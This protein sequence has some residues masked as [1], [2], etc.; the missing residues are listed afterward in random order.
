MG[1]IES[2]LIVY[3]GLLCINVALSAL[4]W[5]TQRTP[6][7]RSL[8]FVW[9]SQA[10]AF[11][12][13]GGSAN[14]SELVIVYAFSSAFLTNLGVA[15]LLARVV[16]LEVPWRA[17]SLMFAVGCLLGGIA[18][19]ARAPFWMF[20]LPVCIAVAAPLLWTPLETLRKRK[21]ALTTTGWALTVTCLAFAAHNL[22][23]AFLRNRP[24]FAVAGFTIAILLAF[25]LGTTA[26][27]VV[28]EREA[29]ERARVEELDRFKSKFF[30]SITHELKTPLT[31]ILASLDL[32]IDGELGSITGL[33]R[34]TLQAA[35]RSGIKLLKLIADLLDLSKLEESRLRLRIEEQDLVAYLRELLQQ[36][37][38]LAERK[39]VSVKFVSNAESVAVWCDLDRLERVFVNLLSNAFKFTPSQG[40]VT[41]EVRD[42]GASVLVRVSD[43]G[44]GF[45]SELAERIFERFYQVDDDTRRARGG[46][47]IG[48]ALARELTELHGGS[49]SA[50]SKPG[51]GAVFS[52]RLLKGREH[53]EPSVLERRLDNRALRTDKAQ[54]K[55]A[56]DVGLAGW[57]MGFEGRYRFID[58]DQATEKRIVERD[59]DES[60]RLHTVLVVDD[61]PDVV[62]VIHLALRQHFRV[63]SAP[64]GQKGFAMAL[65]HRP[66]LLITDLSM[67]EMDGLELTRRLRE[68]ARTRHIPIVMLTARGDL[69]DRVTGLETGVNAY[70]AKPFAPKELLS[71]VRS[72]LSS[73]ENTA[74]LV[75]AQQSASLES[76]AGGLAHEIR[77][78]LNYLK[79]AVLT[80][81]GDVQGL[82]AKLPSGEALSADERAALEKSSARMS[83]M[84]E[85]A[86]S[87]VKRIGRTVDLMLRYG[88]E[89]YARAFE[90]YDVYAA[91]A[92]VIEVVVPATSSD[93]KVHTS[94]LGDG[95]IECV[96]QEL[97][98]ALT[99]VIQNALEAVPPGS[100][101]VEV[102]GRV[103]DSELVLVVRDNGSGIKP[104]DQARIFTPFF[105]TKDVGRGLGMG[106]TITRRCIGALG[107]RVI[108]RSQ[109][110]AGT[111]FTIRLPRE[112][113]RAAAPS[114]AV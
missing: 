34:T 7:N 101:L 9:A 79:N 18:Y 98:Q 90:P 89:G 84:F 26:P 24:E 8:F 39:A 85:T 96:P 19:A 76:I 10:V 86:Q 72:L 13:Q 6:L 112:Q 4:L 92:D 94:L 71:T 60:Q 81:Q 106:L 47:G 45:P 61:T 88:R 111:E 99:N 42:Q 14:A 20:A 31:M 95:T 25:A 3:A 75:L 58:I 74:E 100:G 69:D 78:P 37:A 83:R 68:D 113:R 36:T 109:P 48:L 97:N 51:S 55:R 105:T 28:L 91:I 15:L 35:S 27:A 93:A 56:S 38:P 102:T 2:L 44:P 65:E 30:A 63:F 66:T 110:G 87:G 73:Q 46:A 1:L 107:G 80:I 53:F 103:E 50:E 49:I 41:L 114:L 43:T 64:D 40:T 5:A 52:V 82:M 59:A 11:M 33:Q 62:R 77:N 104:E 32:L 54:G 29:R 70:V 67:P 17:F 22:D 12:A 23:F 16:G 57:D 21:Q 108:V